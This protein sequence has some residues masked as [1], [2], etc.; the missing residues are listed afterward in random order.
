VQRLTT[1][2]R[3]I[4]VAGL[5]LSA[6]PAGAE[7]ASISIELNKLE[8]QGSQCAAYFVITNATS[9]NYQEFKLDLVLFRPDGVIGHR[10]AIDLAPLKANKRTVKLFELADT[11]CDEVGT[12][13]V[14][15]TLRCKSDAEPKVDC[16]NDTTF[17]SLT[18][19]PLTK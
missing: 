19:V 7:Q 10:F 13:L 17:S 11:A 6:A 8:D 5:L 3:C 1:L 16:L 2:V 12:I 15:E 18:K 9:T 4:A 14:N